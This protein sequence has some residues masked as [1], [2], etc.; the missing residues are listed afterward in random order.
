[1][2]ANSPNSA[3]E[4]P[5]QPGVV[6]RLDLLSGFGYV[7]DAEEKYCY[8]FVV[9]YALSHAEVRKLKVGSPVQF[10]TSGRGRVDKLV[11]VYAGHAQRWPDTVRRRFWLTRNCSVP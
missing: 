1:M 11:A 8:I 5:M 2:H 7:S 9:G 10:R 6:V 4:S 3:Q